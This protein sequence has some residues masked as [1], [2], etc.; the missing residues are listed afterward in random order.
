MTKKST[1]HLLVALPSTIPES[2]NIFSSK[3]ANSTPASYSHLATLSSTNG[4]A[5][6]YATAHDNLLSNIVQVAQAWYTGLALGYEVIE[7]GEDEESAPALSVFYPPSH[8]SLLRLGPSALPAKSLSVDTAVVI[9]LDWTKPQSMLRELFTWLA[10]VETWAS[11]AGERGEVEELHERLQ[12]HLQHCTEPSPAIVAYDIRSPEELSPPQTVYR[13]A[14]TESATN[15]PKHR[16]G[17]RHRR[18]YHHRAEVLDRDAVMV[19]SGWDSWGK[20]GKI[21]RDGFDPAL[22]EK[23]W[24]IN[25]SRYIAKSVGASSLLASPPPQSPANLTTVSE[26]SQNFLFRQFDLLMKA[27]NRDSRQ[28]FRHAASATSSSN[29][30]SATNPGAGGFDNTAVGHMGGAAEGFSLP[31]VEKVMQEMEGELREAREEDGKAA[32]GTPAPAMPNEALH[33]FF[34]GLLANRGKTGGSAAVTPT[35]GTSAEGAGEGK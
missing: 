19:P 21:M 25:L 5:A 1:R 15:L 30:P 28:S 18:L 8:P 27:P 6:A 23:G 2:S 14:S 20:T 7:V 22:V 33:N 24:K 11:E 10:C 12:S 16:I 34:Q 35:K 13:P 9:V 29:V 31:G 32:P 17:T 26:P 4:L 3:T